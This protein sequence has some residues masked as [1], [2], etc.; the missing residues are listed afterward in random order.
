V[1]NSPL[2]TA[3]LLA[4][5]GGLATM[6]LT[7]NGLLQPDALKFWP[8][9][10]GGGIL[11]A[12]LAE[13]LLAQPD[14]PSKDKLPQ[15]LVTLA[16]IGL[17]TL[18]GSRLFGTL[19]W[20]VLAVAFL[21]L[22]SPRIAGVAVFFWLARTLVQGFSYQY[23]L[24]LTGINLTHTYVTAAQFAGVTLML[25][26]PAM[27]RSWKQSAAVPLLLTGLAVLLPALSNYFLHA[28]AAGSL[29]LA[30]MTGA[31]PL[32]VIAPLLLSE[33][34]AVVVRP[35]VPLTL[36]CATGALATAPLLELGQFAT[37]EDQLQVLAGSLVAIGLLVFLLYRSLS[38][39]DSVKVA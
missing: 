12:F 30:L 37:R 24:N 23:N 5:V 14:A 3:G 27:A 7:R 29:L 8:C 9:L 20:V 17:G 26:I 35:L 38:G 25:L 22:P 18:V 31:V 36:V 33:T 1:W 2:Q 13:G 11:L 19:G 6:L 21:T 15:V 34:E 16:V 39:R 28:E 4:V 32:T 10:Y